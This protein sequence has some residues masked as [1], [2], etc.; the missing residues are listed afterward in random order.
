MNM[1]DGAAPPYSEK[2]PYYDGRDPNLKE[3]PYCLDCRS[4]PVAASLLRC[5]RCKMAWY[6]NSN[7]QIEHYE[8]HYELCKTIA[9]ETKLVEK[10]AYSLRN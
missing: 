6:C 4:E 8:Q 10:L 9:K 3:K 2:V 1:N 7:F 5:S